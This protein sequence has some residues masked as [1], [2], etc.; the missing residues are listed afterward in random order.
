MRAYFDQGKTGFAFP[1]AISIFSNLA[2]RLLLLESWA[3][4]YLRTAQP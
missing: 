4:H 2:W 1:A 3:K